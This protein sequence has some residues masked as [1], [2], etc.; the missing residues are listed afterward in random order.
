MKFYVAYSINGTNCFITAKINTKN[1]K[2]K[3]VKNEPIK[4]KIG[5]FEFTQ[6]NSR[7][8]DYKL[9]DGIKLH[10]NRLLTKSGK[11]LH[12]APMVVKFFNELE[13]EGWIVDKAF[14]VF[15][16]WVK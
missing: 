14:F 4:Y 16:H 7:R 10:S 3:P 2:V 15:N 8:P 1:V 6:A 5:S 9:E 11:P 12:S 13:A